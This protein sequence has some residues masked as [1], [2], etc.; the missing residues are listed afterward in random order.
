[1]QR[2][3]RDKITPV[4]DRRLAPVATVRAGERFVVETEDSRGGL[5]RTPETTTPEYLIALRRRGYHGNPVTGPIF[6]EGA[7]PGD[8][9][10][11]HIHA[12]E[13]DTLGYMA[14]WPWLFNLQDLFPEPRTQLCQIQDG[15]VLFNDEIRIPVRPMIGTIGTAPALEAILSGGMGRHGGNLD[16]EEV[17]PGSTVY[18]PVAV[19][20]GLLCLGDCHAVQGD[21][22]INEVEMRSV[23]TLSCDVIKGRPPEMTWPRIETPDL[24]VTVAVGAPLETALNLAVREMILW[25]EALTGLSRHEAYLL[26]GI[27]GHARPGQV[28]V[29]LYSMR[30]LVPK[31]YLPARR[32]ETPSWRD[33]EVGDADR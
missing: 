12:Q 27:A 23:V 33:A 18:L 17:C 14:Y 28:Q 30:Y 29:P 32:S 5:T 2:I 16:V 4:F 13:C 6:V 19:P 24:L 9:L 20:G 7:E 25:V 15:H 26:I 8:T 10:A 21:G 11:V 3:T 1:M 22:E 31:R